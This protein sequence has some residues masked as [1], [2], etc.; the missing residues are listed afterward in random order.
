MAN[1]DAYILYMD[2]IDGWKTMTVLLTG[3]HR[4][5]TGSQLKRMLNDL[6]LLTLS[7]P[8]VRSQTIAIR[9]N[10]QSQNARAIEFYLKRQVRQYFG[11]PRSKRFGKLKLYQAIRLKV[12]LGMDWWDD[13]AISH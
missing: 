13:P 10:P 3:E 9:W 5:Q 11:W 8:T 2:G 1:K 6:E 7:E 12:S 4:F